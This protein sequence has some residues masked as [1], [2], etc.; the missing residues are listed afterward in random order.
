LAIARHVAEQ[1]GGELQL[2]NLAG[3]GF[4]ATVTLERKRIARS[5][6]VL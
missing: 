3:G 2:E 6:D 1:H 5:G 4:A